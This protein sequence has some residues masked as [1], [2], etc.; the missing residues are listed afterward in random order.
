[1]KV[2]RDKAPRPYFVGALIGYL[3]AIIVTVVVMLVFE[4]GQPALLYLVPGVLLSVVI[5]ACRLGEWQKIWEFNEEKL[6]EVKSDK[7]E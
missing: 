3:I 5:N 1:M 2:A 6:I 4:H 7:K